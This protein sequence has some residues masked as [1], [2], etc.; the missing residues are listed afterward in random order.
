M[1]FG[2]GADASSGGERPFQIPI[3][4]LLSA[5]IR[6][7]ATEQ[8]LSMRLEAET[9]RRWVG[10]RPFRVLVDCNALRCLP[11]AC[12]WPSVCPCPLVP[13]TSSSP[14]VSPRVPWLSP[15]VS[16]GSCLP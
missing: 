1:P 16:C 6:P 14:R 4:P 2:S 7:R 13:F 10:V 3:G 5:C 12:E 9:D 11:R 8:H 15:C